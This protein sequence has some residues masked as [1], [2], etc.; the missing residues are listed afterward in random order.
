MDNPYGCTNKTMRQVTFT[1]RTDDCEDISVEMCCNLEGHTHM[2]ITDFYARF[3]RALGYNI[4]DLYEPDIN[5]LHYDNT[6]D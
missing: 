5:D 4:K 1:Y 2:E 3:L 6:V